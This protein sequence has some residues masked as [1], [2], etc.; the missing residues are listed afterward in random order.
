MHRHHHILK[1][2][3]L[4]QLDKYQRMRTLKCIFLKT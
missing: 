1:I 2:S 3:Q 4:F